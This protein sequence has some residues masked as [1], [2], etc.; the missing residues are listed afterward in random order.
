MARLRGDAPY[1]FDMEARVR[2]LEEIAARQDRRLESRWLVELI[3]GLA[4]MVHAF[5]CWP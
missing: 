1:S 2:V 4:L 3:A 5:H